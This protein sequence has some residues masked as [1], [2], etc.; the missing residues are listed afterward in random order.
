MHA[1]MHCLDIT[2]IS[3]CWSVF[4][5]FLPLFFLNYYIIICQGRADLLM[6]D[7]RTSLVNKCLTSNINKCLTFINKDNLLLNVN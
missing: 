4:T 3:T 5:F 1:C 6:S 2:S 7:M